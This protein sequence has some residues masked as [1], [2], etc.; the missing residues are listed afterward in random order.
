[1]YQ[2]CDRGCVSV[3]VVPNEGLPGYRESKHRVFFQ[4][5]LQRMPTK[6]AAAG[7]GDGGIVGG[8]DGWK[9]RKD[10]L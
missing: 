3:P 5:L 10:L 7:E 2:T 9:V 4:Q 6:A 8:M 1:M